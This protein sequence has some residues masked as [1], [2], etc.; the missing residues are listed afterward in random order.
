LASFLLV[1]VL[2]EL[3]VDLVLI[4]RLLAAASAASVISAIYI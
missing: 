1:L 4:L 3:F 2:L